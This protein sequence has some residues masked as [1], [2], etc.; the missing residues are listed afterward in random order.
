M[1]SNAPL[2]Q[3]LAT[4]LV[5]T[6]DDDKHAFNYFKQSLR[7]VSTQGADTSDG[8]AKQFMYANLLYVARTEINAKRADRV[9]HM[10]A[11]ARSFSQDPSRFPETEPVW[12]NAFCWTGSLQKLYADQDVRDA[13]ELAV[14]LTGSKYSSYVD[15]RGLNRALN[16]DFSGAIQDFQQFANDVTTT[17]AL[18]QDRLNWIA[19]LKTGSSPFD[20]DLLERLHRE[21]SGIIPLSPPFY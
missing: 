8:R 11:R 20:R 18:R 4:M 2:Y 7:L 12:L 9:P 15:S 1:V 13:C 16:G 17:P 14:K 6:R 3:K 19:K 5:R 10:Y 21:D